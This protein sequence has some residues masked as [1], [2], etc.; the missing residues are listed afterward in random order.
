MSLCGRTRKQLRWKRIA[1][2]EDKCL[3]WHGKDSRE[4]VRERDMYTILRFSCR[5]PFSLQNKT[6]RI[7]VEMFA[8]ELKSTVSK[9]EMM[10][11]D[12]K[13][14]FHVDNRMITKK[15]NTHRCRYVCI[16]TE[17]DRVQARN[18]ATVL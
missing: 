14:S 17:G 12:N 13:L 9:K 5:Q 15:N 8:F 4:R 11:E 16:R 7:G 18:D 3:R 10:Q 6:T 2:W 1:S